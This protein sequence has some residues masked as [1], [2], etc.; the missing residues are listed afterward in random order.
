M[1]HQRMAVQAF[2]RYHQ[3]AVFRARV[4]ASVALVRLSS[5]LTQRETELASFAAVFALWLAEQP[6]STVNPAPPPN[7]GQRNRTGGQLPFRRPA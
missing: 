4:D 1:M 6:V 3:D 2:A 5:Q 7:P